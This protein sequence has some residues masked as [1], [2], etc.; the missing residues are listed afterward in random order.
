M[1]LGTQFCDFRQSFKPGSKIFISDTL[2]RAYE[3][4]VCEY[5]DDFATRGYNQVHAVI[6]EI[7][8]EPFF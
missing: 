3:D 6:T 8:S 5:Y 2:S 4:E 7:L 1:R